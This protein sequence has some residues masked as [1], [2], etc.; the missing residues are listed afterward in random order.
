RVK[1]MVERDILHPSIII[2]SLGNE[3][4]DGAVHEAAAAHIR[5]LDRSRLVQYEGPLMHDLFAEARAT[6][7]ICP[8]YRSVEE[9]IEWAERTGTSESTE[10]RPLILCE[11]SHAMGNSNGGLVDYWQAVRSHDGLQG[12][13]I[14]EWL[15][16]GIPR[17]TDLEMK[18]AEPT[19]R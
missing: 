2:W 4:G 15:E 13:F 18:T 3:A 7:I 9:I 19:R 17:R 1:R 16:H 8:M 12:G 5:A 6:D 14:W 10:T 11:Y